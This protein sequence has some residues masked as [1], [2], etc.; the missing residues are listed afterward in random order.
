M[1]AGSDVYPHGSRKRRAPQNTRGAR[2][3][4]NGLA[5]AQETRAEQTETDREEGE[6]LRGGRN[7]AASSR[8][9]ARDRA[10]AAGARGPADG[11]MVA[12]A[13]TERQG[14]RHEPG[15]FAE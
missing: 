7:R 9:V 13:A 1:S 15:Q 12:T 10:A 3:E 8:G 5:P 11:R 6:G 4:G 2:R 14:R